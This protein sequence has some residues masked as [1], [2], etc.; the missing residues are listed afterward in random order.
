MAGAKIYN[1][2][3][4]LVSVRMGNEQQVLRGGLKNAMFE[5]DVKVDFYKMGF[6]NFFEMVR[7]VSVTT[8]LGLTV[9]SSHTLCIALLKLCTSSL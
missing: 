5:A 8:S 1:L 3:E 4:S 6:L 7:N 2:Q 9:C